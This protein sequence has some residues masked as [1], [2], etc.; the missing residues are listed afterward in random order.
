MGSSTPNRLR[1]T[2]RR[3]ASC[4]LL[5]LAI[6]AGDA[7]WS[8]SPGRVTR[9]NYERIRDGMT[10][11]EVSALLGPCRDRGGDESDAMVVWKTG[12]ACV[13]V[14]FRHG[15]ASGSEC[16]GTGIVALA[17]WAWHRHVMRRLYELY[18]WGRP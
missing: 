7:W 11:D 16:H 14:Y 18:E 17:K 6:L 4:A 5:A 2:R 8:T 10:D 13:V 15:R 12:P 9:A 3:L 1:L